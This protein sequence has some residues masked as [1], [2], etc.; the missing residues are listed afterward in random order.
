[1]EH[2]KD[3]ELYQDVEQWVKDK[4]I[5]SVPILQMEYKIGYIQAIRILYMLQFFGLIE[6]YSGGTKEVVRVSR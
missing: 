1:M 6:G 4:E 5:V 3:H 2:K